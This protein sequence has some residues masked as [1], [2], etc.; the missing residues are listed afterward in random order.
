MTGRV[1]RQARIVRSDARAHAYDRVY[2]FGDNLQRRGYGGQAREL[3]GEP[4]AVGVP[5]KR[6]P[7]TMPADYFTD[8]DLSNPVVVGAI[9]AA[10][11][12]LA[13]ALAEGKDVVI[14][15]DGLGTGLAELP[16]R[17]P[18]VYAYIERKIGELG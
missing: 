9:D 11:A 8:A 14:P 18:L 12:L 6:A 10:F 17:A 2:A 7:T 13:A 4:N 3:R 1:V 15:A 5:T 16:A